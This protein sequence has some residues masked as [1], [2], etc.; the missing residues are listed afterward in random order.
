MR[1]VRRFL[2]VV[3]LSLGVLPWGAARADG[4]DARAWA[5]GGRGAL[6]RTSFNAGSSYKPRYSFAIGG[7]LVVGGDA[8]A[9]GGIQFQGELVLSDKKVAIEGGEG[10]TSEVLRMR[11][12]DIPLLV[13]LSARTAAA[14]PFLVAGPVVSALIDAHEWIDSP[15]VHVD[16]EHKGIESSDFAFQLGAGAEM[17]LGFVTPTLDF[18]YAHG[19]GAITGGEGTP[20]RTRVFALSLGALF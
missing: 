20:R 12:I 4:P 10:G 16:R 6:Q 14:R 7:V 13:R 2:L 11:Y 3:S 5:I 1:I 17:P 8:L 9:H 18:R 15:T 19:F